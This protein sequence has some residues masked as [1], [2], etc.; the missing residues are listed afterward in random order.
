MNKISE[1]E[2]KEKLEFLSV[3]ANQLSQLAYQNF[4]NKSIVRKL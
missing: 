2:F 3:M 1:S 4:K